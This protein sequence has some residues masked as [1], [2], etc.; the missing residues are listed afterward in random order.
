M[1]KAITQAQLNKIAKMVREWPNDDAFNWQNI[2]AGS[3]TILGYVPTRQ[4]L[5]AK[6]ILKNAYVVKKKQRKDAI[7]KFKDVPRPQS[8]LEAM[9]KIDRLQSENELL[10][11]EV[12]RMAEVAQRFIANASIA[13]LSAERLMAPLPKIRRD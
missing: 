7:E 4:G 8:M 10:R 12:A 1:P 2:C 11:A 6:P 9:R 3:K 13:G 5:S